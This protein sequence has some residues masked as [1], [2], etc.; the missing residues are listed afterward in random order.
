MSELV[1][2]NCGAKITWGEFKYSVSSMKKALC[3]S[4][5]RKFREEHYPKKL[6]ELLNKELGQEKL[7]NKGSA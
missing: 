4:C 3:Q 7:T 6:A 2:E 5:Q 1:C